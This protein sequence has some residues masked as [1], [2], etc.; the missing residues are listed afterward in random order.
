M[1]LSG[2]QRKSE[3][4]QLVYMPKIIP[5][6]TLPIENGLRVYQHKGNMKDEILGVHR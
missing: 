2:E 1:F 5:I 6:L 3:L 4:V